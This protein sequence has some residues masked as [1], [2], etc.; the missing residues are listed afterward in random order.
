MHTKKIIRA[1]LI[2]F[3]ALL[4]LLFIGAVLTL[5]TQAFKR[6]LLAKIVRQAEQSTGARIAIQKLDVHWFPFTADVYGV[7]VHGQERGDDPPLLQAEHL[8]VSLGIRALLKKSVDLYSVT[9]DQPIV[10]LRIDARGNTNLPKPPASQSSSTFS[11]LIRHASLRDGTVIY[12][13][14]QTPLS[15]ELDGFYANAQY[16]TTASKYRG[17]LGYR[18]GCVVTK[19]TNPV[20]HSA[21]VEF[22]VDRD[23]AVLDPLVVSSGKTHLTTHLK[24]T[25]F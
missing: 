5:H 7:V 12:N 17:S 24:V 18:A 3:P 22:I 2:G 11:V 19:T 4:L 9:A 21:Q 1:V 13:D 23:G 25:N 14:E 20:E 6:F 15:A 8:G 16:E 10:N